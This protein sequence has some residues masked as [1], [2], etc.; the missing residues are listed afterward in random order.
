MGDDGT[1]NENGKKKTNINKQTKNT[2]T[3]HKTKLKTLIACVSV[4][5]AS[6]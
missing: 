2:E 1:S 6:F 3:K 4:V 5:A